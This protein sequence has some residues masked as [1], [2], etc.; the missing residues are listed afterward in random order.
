M[1]YSETVNLPKTSFPMKAQLSQR[2]PQILNRWRDEALY[3]KLS[4][5]NHDRDPFILHDGPPY[6]NGHIHIGHALNK[7]LKDFMIKSRSMSGHYCPYIPG[8]D[9]HGLPIEYQ[10]MKDLGSR[11]SE[12]NPLQIRALCR[13]YADKYYKIQREEFRR[14]GILGDW[15]HPYLTM[16]AP[17]EAAIVREFAKLVAQGRVYKRKKPVLWCS[18]DETALA[19]A[20]VEYLERTSPSIYVKFP[21]VDPQGKFEIDP[22][23]G[24]HLVIWTTTPWTLL[25]NRAISLHPRLVYRLVKTPVGEL[26]IAQD[27]LDPC[28][29]TFGFEAEEVRITDGGWTGQELEGVRCRH[30]WLDLTVPVVLGEHVTQEQGTGCVHTAPGHGQEDFEVGQRYGLE[31]YVPVDSKGRFIQGTGD[32]GEPLGGL[33]VLKAN[34]QIIRLLS[35]RGML[36]REETIT[37]SYPHCWRCKSPIIFRATEQWFISLEILDLRQKALEEIDRV[38]WIPRWG[39]DRI[40]GMIQNRPDWCISRQRAWGVPIVAFHCLSCENIL[41]DATVINH[42]ADR[43]EQEGADLW[44]SRS[45]PELLPPGTRCPQCGGQSFGKEM[46]ILDVWFESGV[47]HAGVLKRRAELS[48]PADLYLEGSDQHR[49]WFHSALLTSV[50]TEGSAPYRTVLTHGFV[51]DGSGKKMSKSAGNVIA[52]QEVTDRYGAEVLRLWVAAEDYREDIRISREILQ[53]LVE[54]YRKIRNTCRFL[55][56]NLYDYDPLRHDVERGDLWE[57][58]RW[59]LG[60][61]S[62]LIGRS[63]RAY[64]QHEFHVVFHALNNFCAVDMSARYFDI[65][66][67]RLYTAGRD[68]IE[69]RAAQHALYQIL[70]ALCKLMAPILS[71][72][73]EEVWQHLSAQSRKASSIHLERFPKAEE[74]RLDPDL[75]SRWERLFTIREEIAKV[76]EQARRKGQIGS[77]LEAEVRLYA[78]GDLLGFLKGYLKDLPM[79]L[80]VSSVTLNEPTD[81]IEEIS[82]SQAVQGL[83]IQ[84]VKAAGQK[85]E[86]CWNYRPTVGRSSQHPT[87]CDPC[88]KVIC[89]P[90]S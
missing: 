22:L 69:R 35:E 72:T 21:V 19:E 34:S 87:L 74:D 8:W 23:K 90:A 89:Q 83:G 46:D 10:V 78:Q 66:K 2:E 53:Q 20:E 31:V 14:L 3:E 47:S 43:M 82:Q 62:K 29:K 56:G 17:Y 68:S 30:P 28:L 85:C 58:D 32:A 57:V 70:T 1:G 60:R 52:P 48:W 15:D 42:V 26:I 79:I 7:I 77:S 11:R 73:A 41:L 12:V 13:D 54:A 25:A 39:R 33:H 44:F 84:A 75:L 64:E 67:D 45:A 37:H 38:N 88:L 50:C 36:L 6:A 63:L 55:L 86:R 76:L 18:R 61:L 71:F 27:L 51:V 49:G 80:I 16:D 4:Q 81:G 24:T 5:K 59:A 65:L 9:C 40:Y